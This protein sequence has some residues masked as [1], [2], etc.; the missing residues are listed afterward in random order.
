MSL[1]LKIPQ[2]TKLGYIECEPNGCFDW[3]YPTSKLRRGRVQWGG[4]ISPTITCHPECI[5]VYE[6]K[7]AD[8]SIQELQKKAKKTTKGLGLRAGKPSDKSLA[9]KPKGKGWQFVITE[10]GRLAWVRLRKLTC[11]ECFRLMNVDEDKID[12]LLT[13]GI[14]DSQLYKMA[15]NSIVVACMEGIFRNLFSA[16]EQEQEGQLTLF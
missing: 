15:G 13:A 6:L 14:S 8:M 9:N 7:I 1:K 10:D 12:R 16:E 2:A 4:H 3:T 11:R 5:Y